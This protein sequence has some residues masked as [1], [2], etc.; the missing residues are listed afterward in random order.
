MKVTNLKHLAAAINAMGNGYT[1]V[2]EKSW[3]STDTKIAGTRLRRAGKGRTGLKLTVKDP[4]GEVV[5]SCDTSHTTPLYSALED[6]I[7]LFGD[8]IDLDP[9]ELYAVGEYVRII[10]FGSL[11]GTIV[12]VVMKNKTTAKRYK[13]K[14]RNDHITEVAPWRIRRR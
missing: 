9:G 13:V 7:R 12:A 6:A 8:K 1:A 14:L 4:K 2:A 5:L 11:Y 3:C 10:D